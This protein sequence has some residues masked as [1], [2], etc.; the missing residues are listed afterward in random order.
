MTCM[1]GLRDP[2]HPSLRVT[3]LHLRVCSHWSMPGPV[4]PQTFGSFQGTALVL[5]TVACAG[6]SGLCLPVPVTVH[7]LPR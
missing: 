6:L 4:V 7:M 2:G 3:G 5:V 1:T